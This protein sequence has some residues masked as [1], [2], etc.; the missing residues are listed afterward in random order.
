M[1]PGI[2]ASQAHLL[3]LSFDIRYECRYVSL[4]IYSWM[5]IPIRYECRYVS[6][7]IYSWM[8]IPIRYECRYV[9]KYSLM[10]LRSG[11]ASVHVPVV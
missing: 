10:I 6:L 4:L 3:K 8:I 7:L 9:T 11:H 1:K 2:F 5:I